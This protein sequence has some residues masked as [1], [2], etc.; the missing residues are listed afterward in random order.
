[1][2]L[3]LPSLGLCALLVALPAQAAP[4]DPLAKGTENHEAQVLGWSADGKRFVVRLYQLDPFTPRPALGEKPLCPG[5]VSHEGNAFQ[6]GLVWLVYERSRLISALP[7]LDVKTCTPEQEAQKR[8]E[9]AK[10]KLGSLGIQL[11]APGR[12]ILAHVNTSSID[13]SQGAQAPYTLEYE[14]RATP[15]ASKAPSEMQRGALEQQLYVRKG[16]ARQRVLGRKSSF[17]YST[18]MAGY[19]RTGLDRVWLSPSG[20][21]VV[22]LAYER[23]GNMS[24]G[25]KSLRLLGVLGWSGAALKPL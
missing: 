7:I 22:V 20:S 21:T 14:E 6:G 10:K 5:Y 4:E 9:A 1:M 13:V 18:A 19:L 8:T 25:R 12:E 24:G 23:V 11:D 16:E 3:L 2:N 17:E 15:Q